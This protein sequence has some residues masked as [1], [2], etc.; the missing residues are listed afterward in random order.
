[1]ATTR[2]KRAHTQ[3]GHFQS[4]DPSTP[5][6]NEAYAQDLP[7][8]V[9]SLAAFMEIEQPDDER[10]SR[11]LDLAKEA[12]LTVTGQPVGDFACHG[13][14]HGVHML[15]SQLLIKDALDDAPAAA[16]IPGVVRY[17]WKTANAGR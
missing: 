6:R 12:A 5:E 10:L 11:A 8:N 17:L 7:L 4:D 1:M 14:R 16:D 13:I 15:A 9:A 3:E 2:R